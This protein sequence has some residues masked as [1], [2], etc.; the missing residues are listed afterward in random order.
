MIPAKSMDVL[1]TSQHLAAIDHNPNS[2][3][4]LHEKYERRFPV[5]RHV[6]GQLT[7]VDGGLAY[8]HIEKN[9]LVIPA[10]HYIWVPAGMDHFLQV[11][12]S[13][14]AIRNLYFW[15]PEDA[16]SFYS[17]M[18]IFPVNN[19]LHEMILFTERYVG[20]IDAT[21]QHYV[22]LEA[23]RNVLPELSPRHL[24]TALPTTQHSKLRPI[25]QYLNAH[26]GELLTLETVSLQFGL[27]E[28]SLSRLFQ[29]V[30]SISFLQYL[31][32]LRMVK[33]VELMLQKDLTLSQIA[34]ATGY[35]SISAFSNTFYQLTQIR[36]S[37]F[38]QS[39]RSGLAS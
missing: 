35:N 29:T 32:Q 8:V 4:V 28:R 34:Y 26:A 13:A 25:L 33:A 2:I 6:K 17:E 9:T 30:L 36:P 16:P 10:R 31:K 24:P 37:Q 5:H 39:I 20:D 18:G 15:I 21:D 14:T 22:F 3:Y 1:T 7:Y 38:C 23:L 11:G 12:P 27:S 19:L